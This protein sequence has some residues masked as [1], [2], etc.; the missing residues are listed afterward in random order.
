MLL[1]LI[2]A[3]YTDNDNKVKIAV[4]LHAVEALGGEKI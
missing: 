4:P 3:V 2:I 1:L